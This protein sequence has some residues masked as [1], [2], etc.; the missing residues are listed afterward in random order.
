MS[1]CR[2]LALLVVLAGAAY[3]A[4]AISG[5]GRSHG[6]T[7]GK[8]SLL[9]SHSRVT[10]GSFSLKSTYNFRGSQVISNSDDKYINLNSNI[11]YQNG[12][13]SYIVPLKKKVLIGDKIVFNPNAAT[14][15]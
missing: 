1:A 6:T 10:P 15:H 4:Y 8:R 11:T 14:R 12:R 13:T 7:P 3:A 2:K 9:S 5:D